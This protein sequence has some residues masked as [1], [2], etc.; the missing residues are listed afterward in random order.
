MIIESVER[1]DYHSYTTTLMMNKVGCILMT[2]HKLS[3][4]SP[5]WNHGKL[6]MV[7]IEIAEVDLKLRVGDIMGTQ[8]S[9]VLNLQIVD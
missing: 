6:T 3:N 2:S 4:D 9:G 7:L 8:Q 5:E 1:F